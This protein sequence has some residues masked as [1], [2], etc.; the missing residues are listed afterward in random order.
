MLFVWFFFYSLRFPSLLRLQKEMN[1]SMVCYLCFCL[2]PI[3]MKFKKKNGFTSRP[4]LRN[5]RLM[6][7]LYQREK[8]ILRLKVKLQRFVP[9]I[10]HMNFCFISL[11][12]PHATFAVIT[13]LV[14]VY[15]S[16]CLE[17]LASLCILF[18]HMHQH[19][20]HIHK[21]MAVVLSLFS[22]KFRLSL[23]IVFRCLH[24]CI[25]NERNNRSFILDAR[26]RTM[27]LF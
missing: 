6:C 3:Q 4:R 26:N 8:D 16:Y 13:I 15:C 23:A 5:V 25:R 20:R 22:N 1:N 10:I 12:E 14:S 27:W 19:S 7:Y 18:E 24:R 21:T 9:F 17:L 2:V 11:F